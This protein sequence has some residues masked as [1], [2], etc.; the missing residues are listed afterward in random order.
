[1]DLR[2]SQVD[3]PLAVQY[4]EH[5][6]L[7]RGGQGPRLWLRYPHRTCRR[8]CEAMLTVVGGPRAAHRGAGGFHPDQR[9]QLG[10]RLVDQ[11]FSMVG[12]PGGAGPRLVRGFVADEVVRPDEADIHLLGRAVGVVVEVDPR[13][14]AA[15]ALRDLEVSKHQE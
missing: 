1:M 9:D 2:R 7:F 10:D 11:G 15:A 13:S 8:R 6:G 3:E 4:P 14:E 5:L 12:G